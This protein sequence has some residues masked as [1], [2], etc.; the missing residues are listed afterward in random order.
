MKYNFNIMK[1][2]Y[3][4]RKLNDMRVRCDL[5]NHRCIIEDGDKGKCCVRENSKGKLYTLVYR[6]LISENIDPIEKKPLFHFHP[7]SYS[8]SIATVGCNFKCFF[9]QNHQ[10]SQSPC[11]SER[12]DGRDIT[13]AEIVEHA[14]KY[15]CSSISYTYTEP[16]IFFEYAYDIAK[17]AGSHDLKNIFISNGFMT[18]E[19]LDMIG[20]FLDAA[21][22][23]L[24][25]FS[26]KTYKEKIG[27]RLKPVLDNIVAMKEKGIWI[28]VTTLIIPEI[29][30][31]VQELKS[32]AEFLADVDKSIPWHISAYH[33]QYKSE[34]PAT[35]FNMI[36]N[37]IEIGKKAGLKY[38]YGGN[39]K[40]SRYE[41]TICAKCGEIILERSGFSIINKYIENGRCGKCGEILDGIL[42]D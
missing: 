28:E 15:N 14:V 16:T 18:R 36:E 40:D 25:S 5:C 23:D 34:L 32:I 35:G 13:P 10:I 41:N 21:N 27:G 22:I 26:E 29:N 2:A 9:C 31:S 24:K 17:L 42:L 30:N 3:L 1:E 11:E 8:L 19:C 38:V 37:T 6:K 7:G 39:I 20:P 33:P 12:I 4:Y